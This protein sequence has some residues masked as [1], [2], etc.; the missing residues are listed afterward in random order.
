MSLIE[1][2]CKAFCYKNCSVVEIQKDSCQI[3]VESLFR[4]IGS[5]NSSNSPLHQLLKMISPQE[6]GMIQ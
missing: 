1:F 5:A 2:V 4:V 3:Y 6:L